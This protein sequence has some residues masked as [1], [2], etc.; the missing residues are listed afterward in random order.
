M[1]NIGFSAYEA[2]LKTDEAINHKEQQ[3]MVQLLKVFREI[4][5]QISNGKYE[6]ILDYYLSDV[7]INYLRNLNYTICVIPNYRNEVITTIKW[8]N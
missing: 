3:D 6:L 7:Q 1:S 8:K 2:K 4:E 5:K